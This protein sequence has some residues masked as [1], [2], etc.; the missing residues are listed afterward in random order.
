MN[1]AGGAAA[2]IFTVERFNS[3][4]HHREGHFCFALVARPA[5][6]L[7]LMRLVFLDGV[8]IAKAIYFIN[9]LNDNI[10]ILSIII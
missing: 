7:N 10:V 1:F 2:L 5:E 8:M 9:R 3:A 6:R 4:I